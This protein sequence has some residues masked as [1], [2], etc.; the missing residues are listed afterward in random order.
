MR[1]IG[2]K[3]CGLAG[4]L[5]LIFGLLCLNYTKA[6]GLEHHR[7]VAQRQGL[8]EPQPAIL[9]IGVISTILGSGTIGYVLG[10]RK[11]VG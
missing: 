1:Q 7:A 11:S 2:S 10:K 3:W 5:I 6:H 8:P 4:A 9:R